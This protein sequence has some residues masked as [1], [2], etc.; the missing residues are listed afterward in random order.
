MFETFLSAEPMIRLAA[1][2]GVLVAMALWE[3]AAPRRRR[4]IPRV[5]R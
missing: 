4:Q 2:L 3:V 1:F 5:I